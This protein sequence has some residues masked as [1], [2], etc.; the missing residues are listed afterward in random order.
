MKENEKYE[1][2]PIPNMKRP[3]KKLKMLKNKSKVV[4][5]ANLVAIAP[6]H[7]EDN[8]SV[9]SVI[10]N[11]F[12]VESIEGIIHRNINPKKIHN[13]SIY[14]TLLIGAL[15][16]INHLMINLKDP[17]IIKTVEDLNN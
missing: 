10:L 7:L 1:V 4:S 12:K 6:N 5:V 8:S 13:I 11:T 3:L 17:V 14:V 15:I 16:A 2:K 9:S